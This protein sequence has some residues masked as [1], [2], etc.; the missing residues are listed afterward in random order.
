MR[1]LDLEET[2]VVRPGA[3]F[4]L[5]GVIEEPIHNRIED[6][7]LGTEPWAAR[8]FWIDPDVKDLFRWRGDRAGNG[9]VGQL[10][11]DF[12]LCVVK[13]SSSRSRRM[14]QT[15]RTSES[16]GRRRVVVPGTIRAGFRGHGGCAGRA[17]LARAL[18]RACKIR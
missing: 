10:H 14:F 7:A 11:R 15:A 12:S 18:S 3:P 6:D 17:S 8:A 4:M 1:T 5:D 13:N 9:D 16:S 2:P